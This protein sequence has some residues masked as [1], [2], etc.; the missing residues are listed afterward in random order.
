[1][2]KL[3][4]YY[5]EDDWNNFIEEL[6]KKHKKSNIESILT[7]LFKGDEEVAMVIYK[8]LGLQSLDWIHQRNYSLLNIKPIE[9]LGD[10]N[11]KKR[12][13]V[14]LMRMNNIKN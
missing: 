5:N 3:E 2:I 13:K 6:D 11:L 12:L 7:D 14:K 10:E 9:C 4:R 1:M 8:T